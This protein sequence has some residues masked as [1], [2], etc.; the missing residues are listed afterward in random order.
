MRRAI[1]DFRFLKAALPV[2]AVLSA[3]VISP[4]ANELLK[5]L[6]A[7]SWYKAADTPMR[8]VCPSETQ[9]P[10]IRGSNGCSMVMEGWSGGAYEAGRK[11]LWVWGGGH[12]DYWG[13]ELY[14]FDVEAMKW[15][16]VTDPAP[17]TALS[18]DPMP[19]GSPVSRHTYDGLAFIGHADRLFAYGGSMGGNGYGTQVTWTFD[20]AATKWTDRIPAGKENGPATACCNFNGEY[21]PDSRLVFMRDP[22]W[23]CAYDYDKNAW[24]HV[25][26]WPHLWGPGKTVVDA[27]R[28]LLFTVGSGEFFAY[29]IRGNLDVT[30]RWKTSGGDSLI[31]GW[32]V[33][34][35][36]D[37]HS[38]CLVGWTGG[39]VWVLDMQAKTWSRKSA[40][41]GPAKQ[42]E[43]GTF[44][45][46]RYVP[47]DNVF[48]L[49]NG[50]DEDVY[51][52]KLTAGGGDASAIHVPTSMGKSPQAIMQP[53]GKALGADGRLRERAA[54]LRDF[55]PSAHRLHP[56]S[57]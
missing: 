27:K 2:L 55:R 3:T 39:G 20:P 14:A 13:D 41:G 25:R 44:G 17:I 24:T 4:H 12:G 30:S 47:D 34:A 6:P 46:F 45:R 23:L 28:H 56:Q 31:N 35:A 16:R 18:Q 26:E 11:R 19:D 22:N 15:L 57:P 53:D 7:D 43:N 8:K 21:D 42:L 51:F 29:D 38:D 36:Y 9:F 49:A 40:A 10:D 33:G 32:G 37:A 1:M 48:V 5:N 50:V 54:G 52:Y